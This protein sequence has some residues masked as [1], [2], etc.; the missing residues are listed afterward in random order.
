MSELP[1]VVTALDIMQSTNYPLG[2]KL[3][4][5]SICPGFQVR[6]FAF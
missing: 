3:I 4:N 6:V 5:G 1:T 2:R